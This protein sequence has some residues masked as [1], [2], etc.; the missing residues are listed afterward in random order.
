MERLKEE[1]KQ[2]KKQKKTI[3][4]S[5]LVLPPTRS[6]ETT[7]TTAKGWCARPPSVAIS[8]TRPLRCWYTLQPNCMK[9]VDERGN[10][11][12]PYWCSLY[13]SIIVF[14]FEKFDYR[15][16]PFYHCIF[17]T[18]LTSTFFYV[19]TS[20]LCF[21][22]C[23]SFCMLFLLR[24]DRQVHVF[25]FFCTIYTINYHCHFSNKDLIDT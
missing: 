9:L 25:P 8:S 11:L 7:T 12:F 24:L 17:P 21:L 15:V 13:L 5:C 23:G 22:L 16:C 2:K 1:K 14:F 18:L 6:H 4:S 3:G 20:N 10:L 19:D